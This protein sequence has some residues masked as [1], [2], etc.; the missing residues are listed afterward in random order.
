MQEMMK[1]DEKLDAILRNTS[2]ITKSGNEV[3]R[4]RWHSIGAR[5]NAEFETFLKDKLPKVYD[6]DC[7]TKS[8]ELTN[9]GELQHYAPGQHC[10]CGIPDGVSYHAYHIEDKQFPIP[11]VLRTYIPLR[12]DQT[13]TSTGPVNKHK[14]DVMKLLLGDD[15][16]KL[17]LLNKITQKEQ[18][19]FGY[20]RYS[21]K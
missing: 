5:M 2:T 1:P 10:R 6:P 3:A 9:D 19:F 12:D 20:K 15:D 4:N 7:G 17:E 14:V 8:I 21:M 18:T 13:R 16:W 11:S